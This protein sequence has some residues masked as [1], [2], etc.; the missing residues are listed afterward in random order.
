MKSTTRTLYKI[1]AT[2]R[3]LGAVE[4]PEEAAAIER[5]AT[6]FKVP[7]TKLMA[8]RMMSSHAGEITR[9]DF[10]RK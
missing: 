10:K 4:A 8:R 1:A 5:A 7:A 2:R 9:G 3:R 6:E